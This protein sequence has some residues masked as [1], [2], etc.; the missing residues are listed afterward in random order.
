M[1]GLMVP[2]KLTVQMIRPLNSLT[3]SGQHCMTLF[4]IWG[5]EISNSI[6]K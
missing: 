1:R 3:K 4:Y 6:H 2:S 5:L